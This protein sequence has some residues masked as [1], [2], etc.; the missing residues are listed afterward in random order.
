MKQL[1]EYRT[2]YL[3]LRSVLHDRNTGLAAYPVLFDDLRTLLDRRR[4]LGV[5]HF[6]IVNLDAVESIYGWQVFDR[7]VARAARTIRGCLGDELPPE[8]LIAVN[9]VAGD[10]LVV[11]VPEGPGAVEPTPTYLGGVGEEICRRLQAEFEGDEF[12]GLSPRLWFR[13]GHAL[14]AENPF[15]RFERCVYAA[16]EEAR[17]L[18][19]VR[20]RRRE[21]SWGEEL[22]RIISEG[23]VSVVFQPVL[24]LETGGLLGHEAFVR[25]PDGSIFESPRSMFALSDRMGLSEELD[26]VC[27]ETTLPRFSE[28]GCGGKLFLNIL[29]TSLRDERWRRER[30]PALLQ[31][32]SLDRRDV[33]LEISERCAESDPGPFVV[34]LR[35]FKEDGFGL[36]LDDVGTG[37]SGVAAVET[38]RPDYLKLDVSLV[39]NIHENLIQQD[40]LASLVK[41]ADDIDAGLIAEGVEAQAEAATLAHAGARYAQGF[42]FAPPEA[43]PQSREGWA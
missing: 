37:R 43:R 4:E 9:G 1:H 30:L 6:E 39:R 13:S 3:K 41:L 40:V 14:L 21:L 29:P 24:E 20:E 16:V 5:L 32:C 2:G 27:C 28:L 26:R 36:A 22:Q 11:F 38:L 23:R 33:V 25:G 34:A 15:F 31:S 42:L 12:A 17:A 18:H 8:S 35:G 7:I 19:G 10:R